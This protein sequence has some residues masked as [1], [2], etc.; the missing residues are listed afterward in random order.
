MFL[1][2]SAVKIL[3]AG[4]LLY[5]RIQNFHVVFGKNGFNVVVVLESSVKET[6]THYGGGLI[7]LRYHYKEYPFRHFT[8]VMLIFLLLTRTTRGCLLLYFNNAHSRIPPMS[9]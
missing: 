2:N 7:R 5:S 8:N 9:L 6:E 1:R 4:V 3:I